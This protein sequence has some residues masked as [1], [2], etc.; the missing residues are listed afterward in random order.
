MITFLLGSSLILGNVE[1]ASYGGTICAER[2]ALVR[3]LAE[4]HKKFKGIAIAT[5]SPDA[6][7]PCGICRQFMFEFGDMP[8]CFHFLF[9]I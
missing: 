6:A 4:G 5:H 1:N 9:D 8:V 7:S 3:A 2:S